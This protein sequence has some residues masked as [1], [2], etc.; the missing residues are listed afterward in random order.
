[1][2]VAHNDRM[3]TQGSP[4]VA[5]LAFG[6]LLTS[7]RERSKKTPSEVAAELGVDPSTYRRWESGKYAPKPINVPAIAK[8]VHATPDEMS[9]MSTLSLDAKQR[10]LFEGRNV[11]AHLRALYELESSARRLWSL[12]L[13]HIPGL[14]QTLEYHL[15]LQEYQLPGD[16]EY[17][18]TLRDLRPKR[19]KIMFGRLDAPEL[20]F[21]IGETALRY[22]EQ[23]PEVRDPQIARLLEVNRLP[24]VEIRVITGMH[25][26]MLSSFTIFEPPTITRARPF[27]HMETLQGDHF[28]EGD[29]VSEKF[30][31]TIRLIRDTQSQN[32]EDYLR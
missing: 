1:M 24:N 4:N 28:V 2:F 14:L 19:Q 23:R 6:P 8:A 7:I 9:R 22:L 12:E 10:G 17:A 3:S 31:A 20:L 29:V 18:A 15:M 27:V 5:K 26:G 30:A 13:E 32:L 21:L 25:A 16:P 11:P